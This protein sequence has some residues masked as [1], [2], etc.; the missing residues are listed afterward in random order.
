[1]EPNLRKWAKWF[2]TAE[3]HVG[4]DRIRGIW[5]S[6]VF[7]GIDHGWSFPPDEKNPVLWETMIFGGPLDQECGRCPGSREQAHAMHLNT[8]KIVLLTP[9]SAADWYKQQTRKRRRHQERQL[10]RKWH[11]LLQN[12][13][14]Q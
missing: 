4:D 7:L 5:I 6:T 13:S 2:E 1:M 10:H 8:V 9:A 12:G 11:Y 14:R 3:R